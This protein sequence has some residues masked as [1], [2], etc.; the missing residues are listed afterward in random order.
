M[1]TLESL[2]EAYDMEKLHRVC[3]W[4]KK[5]EGS[6]QYTPTHGICPECMSKY[7]PEVFRDV[8]SNDALR[9]TTGLRKRSIEIG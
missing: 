9:V 4:C 7:F 6:K 8:R 5:D 3:A 1:K 2:R